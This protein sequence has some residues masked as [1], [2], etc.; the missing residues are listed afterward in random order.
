MAD[1]YYEARKHDKWLRKHAKE[2]KARKERMKQ[3]QRTHS[4]DHHQSL[5]IEG[6]AC[7]LYRDPAAGAVVEAALM[8]WNGRRDVLIDRFDARAVLD[9]VPL[10][11]KD[12]GD[13]REKKGLETFLSFERYRGIVD[14]Q[15][16]GLGEEEHAFAVS[17]QVQDKLSEIARFKKG[18]P[19][20]AEIAA[21][22]DAQEKR[23]KKVSSL[24]GV[25]IL[26]TAWSSSVLYLHPSSTQAPSQP[27]VSSLLPPLSHRATNLFLAHPTKQK[28]TKAEDKAALKEAK[29][30]GL[31]P[32][33]LAL[34]EKEVGGGAA[35][36][37]GT[38]FM[39]SACGMID[40]WCFLRRQGKR[41]DGAANGPATR[42]ETRSTQALWSAQD[43]FAEAYGISEKRSGYSYSRLLRYERRHR[44]QHRA[45]RAEE[46]DAAKKRKRPKKKADAGTAGLED[47]DPG[48]GGGRRGGS[49]LQLGSS[50]RDSPTYDDF[51]DPLEARRKKRREDRQKAGVSRD[52]AGNG[53]GRGRQYI[54]SFEV[55]DSKPSGGN[56]G[57][58][59]DGSLLD[60]DSDGDDGGGGG[61]S[62]LVLLENFF[63]TLADSLRKHLEIKE[64]REKE[65]EAERERERE[66]DREREIERAR[67]R[68]AAR[69]RSRSSSSS[70]HSGSRRGSSR[71]RGE[72][73]RRSRGRDSRSR[74][75]GRSSSSSRRRYR[76]GDGGRERSGRGSGGG[77]GESSSRSGKTGSGSKQTKAPPTK[78]DKK[79]TPM[80]M[81]KLRMRKALDSQLQKDKTAI[82]KKSSKESKMAELDRKQ[83]RLDEEQHERLQSRAK[84][85]G[86]SPSR[87]RSRSPP[88]R[89][90]RSRSR[91][92]SRDRASKSRR[93][94]SR[95]RDGRGRGHRG[96]SSGGEDG[97]RRRQ[98]R[99]RSR[100]SSGSRSRSVSSHRWPQT[101]LSLVRSVMAR[102]GGSS[103]ERLSYH[104]RI[105]W[106]LSLI[107]YRL[108]MFHVGAEGGGGTG[109]G[110]FSAAGVGS[111]WVVG[112]GVGCPWKVFPPV[113]QQGTTTHDSY[114]GSPLRRATTRGLRSF[115]R[116]SYR[117]GVFADGEESRGPSHP[118]HTPSFSSVYRGPRTCAV[119]RHGRQRHGRRVM[120]RWHRGTFAIRE[121]Q[122]AE[123]GVDPPFRFVSSHRLV[124]RCL[125][126]DCLRRAVRY[127]A[128]RAT[129]AFALS[130]LLRG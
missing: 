80:E 34:I 46:M 87:S 88:R 120:V 20:E 68:A 31:D 4:R 74:S 115:G 97:H 32:E 39:I 117:V 7:K 119:A 93:R 65:L 3:F 76:N 82:A 110:G 107:W 112:S 27:S 51:G 40:D 37:K 127:G 118:L 100:S 83:Q 61:G 72:R 12:T 106:L 21:A 16:V 45:N 66:R 122:E 116:S 111:R 14:A 81:M 70:R 17:E 129:V 28:K 94:D 44:A 23:N 24:A 71:D 67:R 114:L 43:R 125:L 26:Q 90:R 35:G 48:T 38:G 109:S 55:A 105:V 91:S 30:A 108:C 13:H 29:N 18:E 49:R 11:P 59:S 124:V 60:S 62:H 2:N 36:A 96:S 126:Q 56:S 33:I 103:G 99:R 128:I 25:S 92:S 63:P 47:D 104:T 9:M 73:G 19:D 95:D 6:N 22:K 89:S 42:A 57:S 58:G 53:A 77:G 123:P 101:F 41:A 75:R 79:L 10:S 15:R 86:D 64:A 8:P 98:R 5:I 78:G 121:R 50:V 85:G 84:D 52:A 102:Q 130:L 54:S 113:G 1:Y 69:R